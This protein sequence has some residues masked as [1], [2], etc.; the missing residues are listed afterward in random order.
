MEE[1]L[2]VQGAS[3]EMSRPFSR[4]ARLHPQQDNACFT[5]LIEAEC[6]EIPPPYWGRFAPANLYTLEWQDLWV[7]IPGAERLQVG[8]QT[9]MP[10]SEALP[11]L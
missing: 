1:N 7:E 6:Q 8:T 9:L 10:V 3:E 4:T 2:C 5:A 11:R